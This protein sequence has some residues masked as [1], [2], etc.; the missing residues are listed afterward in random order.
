MTRPSQGGRLAFAEKA[1]QVTLG[2]SNHSEH[3]PLTR[4]KDR[5]TGRMRKPPA[6]QAQR[7]Q[8]RAIQ[9]CG[10]GG[11]IDTK[12]SRQQTAWF[13]TTADYGRSRSTASYLKW[14]LCMT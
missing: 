9:G 3:N 8:I 12:T 10:V 14:M 6:F 7:P 2:R 1:S 4:S 13:L 5:G 11:P